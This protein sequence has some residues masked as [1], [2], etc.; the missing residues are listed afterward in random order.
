MLVISIFL[1]ALGFVTP[2][3][4]GSIVTLMILLYVFLSGFAG[5]FSQRFLKMF[6]ETE[7]LKNAILTTVLYPSLAFSTLFIINIFLHLE[8]SSGAIHFGTI[9]TLLVLWLCCSSPLV[10]IGAFL[11][12]KKKPIKNPGNV[13]I[14]PSSIPE[15]PWYLNTKII[16]LIT[17]IIPFWYITLN[18]VQSV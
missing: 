6:N 5:Y 18:L 8:G 3:K 14:V 9:I 7:W 15:Q 2:E 13:N 16:C 4:R 1:A 17:G 12:L 10:L 11:G